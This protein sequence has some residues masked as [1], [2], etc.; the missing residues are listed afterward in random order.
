MTKHALPYRQPVLVIILQPQALHLPN[1]DIHNSKQSEQYAY[2]VTPGRSQTI[3]YHEHTSCLSGSHVRGKLWKIPE[4]VNV[5]GEYFGN[6][7]R[8][9]KMSQNH[10]LKK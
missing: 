9:R 2:S 1:M 8:C 7:I 5:L 10:P 4:L 3:Q 6:E